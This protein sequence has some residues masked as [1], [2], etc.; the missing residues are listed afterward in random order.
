[1]GEPRDKLI[2]KD[3]SFDGKIKVE[4]EV[5]QDK[6]SDLKLIPIFIDEY[7]KVHCNQSTAYTTSA[8]DKSNILIVTKDSEAIKSATESS[9]EEPKS[10][11]LGSHLT[12][13]QPRLPTTEEIKNL[14]MHGEPSCDPPMIITRIKSRQQNSIYLI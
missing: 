6:T 9:S 7:N 5:P 1:L 4:K 3:K 2:P 10:K 14:W 8:R 13:H 12:K 11:A